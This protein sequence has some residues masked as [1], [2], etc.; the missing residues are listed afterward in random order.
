MAHLTSAV[1][2]QHIPLSQQ[3]WLLTAIS[4]I[5]LTLAGLGDSLLYLTLPLYAVPLGVPLIWIGVILSIN[6][7]IRLGGNHVLVLTISRLGYKRVAMLGVLLASVSTLAYG[8]NPPI[9]LWLISRVAWGLAYAALR[10]QPS[11]TRGCAMS[12]MG[13]AQEGMKGI[14]VAIDT[15]F[16][17]G[18]VDLGSKIG[19]GRHLCIALWG[20]MFVIGVA[21]RVFRGL[22]AIEVKRGKHERRLFVT[23]SDVAGSDLRPK[24]CYVRRVRR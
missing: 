21:K 20:E 13:G 24:R 15:V 11:P 3:A 19:W 4:A 9:W 1:H 17:D 8:M 12:R 2:T 18:Y 14:T 16:M 23:G 22:A 7:L 6:K 5:V 10:Y